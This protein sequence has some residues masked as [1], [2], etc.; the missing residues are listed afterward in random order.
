VIDKLYDFANQYGKAEA[1]KFGPDSWVDKYFNKSDG[2]IVDKAIYMTEYNELKK[3][4]EAKGGTLEYDRKLIDHMLDLGVDEDVLLE[5][6]SDP[7]TD[8]LRK[9]Y[10]E[11][12]EAAGFSVADWIDLYKYVDGSKKDE[13]KQYARDMGLDEKQFEALW[14]YYYPPKKK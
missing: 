9:G 6:A 3:Q 8:K 4:A 14:K 10:N 2:K 7:K 11:V 13:V 1:T 5:S 12:G